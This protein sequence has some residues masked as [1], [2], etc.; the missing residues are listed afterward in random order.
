MP[1]KAKGAALWGIA[2]GESPTDVPAVPPA[3]RAAQYF[4]AFAAI[5]SFSLCWLVCKALCLLLPRPAAK[6]ACTYVCKA[7]FR[8]PLA[9]SPWVKVVDMTPGVWA[10]LQR[11]LERGSACLI[12]NHTSFMDTLVFVGHAPVAC[13]KRLITLMSSTLFKIP[14]L[15]DIARSVGH[16]PVYFLRAE[17]DSFSLDK[18]RMKPSVKAMNEHLDGGGSIVVFPEGQLNKTPANLLPFRR[19]TFGTAVER[20]LPLWGFVF[21]GCER[22]W[23]L[24]EPVG[25]FP[26]TIRYALFPI[27]DGATE[28]AT[29][30]ELMDEAKAEMQRQLDALRETAKAAKSAAQQR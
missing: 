14:L 13:S 15:G 20:K 26:A 11:D 2:A 30:D 3:H 25:G 27:T 28:G 29:A 23:P 22:S 5:L 4:F 18:E 21:T 9:V 19:G 6:R 12:L 16:Q 24:R 10:D 17:E 7:C 1:H 8:L